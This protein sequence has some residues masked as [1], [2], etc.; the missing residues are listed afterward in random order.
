MSMTVKFT[1]R[2]LA[3]AAVA[4]L[5]AGLLAPSVPAHGPYASALSS[6]SVG[7]AYAVPINCPNNSCG[8][9]KGCRA[10]HGFYCTIASDGSCQNSKCI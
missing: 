6:L 8:G 9:K 5:A 2:F 4:A 10:D 3:I 1:T 7:S